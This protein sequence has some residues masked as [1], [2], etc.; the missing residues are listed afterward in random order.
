MTAEEILKRVDD[1]LD[2]HA[3]PQGARGSIYQDPY[4]SDFFDLCLEAY[5]KGYFDPSSS[6]RLTGDAMSDRF[7]VRWMDLEKEHQKKKLTLLKK[8]TQMWDEWE[9]ALSKI[10][11]TD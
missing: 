4:K 1:Y 9:Y 5:V 2:Q 6:P 7:N 10:N 3:D 11:Y 8:L